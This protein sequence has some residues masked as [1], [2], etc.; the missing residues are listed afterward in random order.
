MTV[1]SGVR[2]PP[3]QS[4]GLGL[5]VRARGHK[6]HRYLRRALVALKLLQ[7]L[8]AVHVRHH[9]VQQDEV[10]WRGARQIQPLL[11]GG[12]EL[13]LGQVGQRVPEQADVLDDVIDDEN[14]RSGGHGGDSPLAWACNLREKSSRPSR[15]WL[16]RSLWVSLRM[17][18]NPS[19]HLVPC[20]LRPMSS[21]SGL[22][23]II[24][25]CR[26]WSSSRSRSSSSGSGAVAI[27]AAG[28]VAV[29]AS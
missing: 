1:F 15:A 21:A 8:E 27:S 19:A 20:R 22:A 7:H 2:G 17:G 26:A 4:P 5:Y 23:F 25:P 28:V 16:K 13:H 3:Y 18:A 29:E 24:L 10:R 9:H 14:V 12:R 11:A 6:Q